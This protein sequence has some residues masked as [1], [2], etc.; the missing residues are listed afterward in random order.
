MSVRFDVL[1][2]GVNSALPSAGRHQSAQVLTYKNNP[3]LIDCGEATQYRLSD[4]KVKRSKIKHIFISHLHGDHCYGLPGLVN[5][6][7]LNG[8]KDTLHIHGPMGVDDYLR[9][10]LKSSGSYTSYDIIYKVYSHERSET[11]RLDNYLEVTT[12]PL[13]HRIPTLG[14]KFTE[15]NLE[16]NLDLEKRIAY[17]LEIA[18]I[19]QLKNGVTV[20]R[21]HEVITPDD[22]LH[23]LPTPRSYAYCSDTAYNESLIP[24]IEGVDLLYHETTYLSELEELATERKHTTLEKALAIAKKAKAKSFISGHYS[25]RYPDLTEFDLRGRALFD[26]FKLGLEGRIY[27][28]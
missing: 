28:I 14:Y 24:L 13:D 4:F 23:P 10:V 12:L 16:R 22:V 5:S 21:A 9:H 17:R 1:L 2:L 8:R 15:I 19:K 6:F 18:E 27:E 25:S 20:E 26:G 3:I 11:F 7:T